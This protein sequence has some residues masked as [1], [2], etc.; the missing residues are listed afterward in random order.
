MKIQIL[1]LFICCTGIYATDVYSQDTKVTIITKNATLKE[2]LHEIEEK[3]DYLFL[4]NQEEVD[5]NRKISLKAKGKRVSH[6]L[7][8]LFDNTDVR[9]V[10]EGNNIVLMKQNAVP[11]ALQAAVAQQDSRI[12]TGAVA[13]KNGEP[14]I[15]ANIMEKGSTNGTITDVDGKFSLN[16]KANAVLQVS[17]I[18][19]ATQEIKVGEQKT[20]YVK[21]NEDAQL[22]EEVVVTA[23]G[24]KRSEK[25]LGY[26]VQKIGGDQFETV[27]GTNIAT[28]LTGRIS[29]LTVFNPT[30]F[31]QDPTVK[32]RGETAI[33]VLDGVPTDLAMRDLNQDDIENINI[34]KGATA[35]ALYG[36]RGG[37]GAIMITTKKSGKK[38]FSVT[39]N[40]SDMFNMGELAL[41]E[42]QTSYSSGIGGKYSIYTPETGINTNFDGVWG[43]KLDIGREAYQWNPYAKEWQM[44]PLTSRGKN[45]FTNFLEASIISNT[46][47][48]VT[49]Q[50]ENGSIR[51]S[52]SYLYNKGQ[53]PNA[54]ANQFR[55]TLGGEMKLGDK[56]SIEGTLG[57][58]KF[59]SPNVSGWG[60]SDQGYIYTLSVWT[61]AEYDVRDYRDYWT[62]PNEQQNWWHHNWYDNPYMSAYEKLLTLDRNKGNGMVS[63]NYQ[64]L[65][66]LK[67]MAR[68][69][70]DLYFNNTERRAP[71][72]IFGTRPWGGTSNGYYS[73]ADDYGYNM[74][75]D[76][77]L[78]YDKKFGRFS[79]DGMLGGSLYSYKKH[80]LN[81]YT[82]GGLTIPG[83]YSLLASVN[84][85]TTSAEL[86]RKA[87]SSV[88]GQ[89][90]LGYANAVYVDV[91]GRNDWSSTLPTGD[92]AYFY[93]SVGGSV[94]LSELLPL[95]E[96]LPFWK[97]RG[98]W[99]VTKSD[100]DIYAINQAY[101]VGT[102]AW[103]TLPSA[104]YPTSL[105]GNVEP[106][107]NR[108]YEIGTA[109]WLLPN[110]R[111]K[112]DVAYFNKL[113]YNDTRAVTI[114]GFTGFASMLVNT[115]EEFVRR[116]WEITLD[117]MPVK[118]NDFSWNSMIN[119]SASHRYFSQLDE[120]YSAD[121]LYT[122]VGERTDFYLPDREFYRTT[123]G[124]LIM[125][126]NG[127]PTRSAYNYFAGYTEPDWI[128]G[129]TNVFKYKNLSL[130]LSFD[131]RT[132]GVSSSITNTRLW[133]TG[134][135]PDSDIPERYEEVVNGN[136]TFVA[137]GVKLVSGAV[138]YDSY[139][140]I[141]P[142]SDT[143]VYAPN[144]IPVSYEAYV[145]ATGRYL[146]SNYM[147]ETFFKLREL[148]LGYDLPKAVVHKA[149]LSGVTISLI[150][151]N[152]LLWTKEYR[153]ADPD[154][155]HSDPADGHA[156]D[157]ASPSVR[158]M[159]INLKVEF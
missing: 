79:V 123:D 73:D 30:E 129:W 126:A 105:R 40:T 2:V 157:L 45:N 24:M 18:G 53:Y 14:I 62:K 8:E 113:T 119:W 93:P 54:K 158:Y 3:T 67:V 134:A 46:S 132:G 84:T 32:L 76:F 81:S 112:L 77:I 94:I 83:Y 57:F 11:T 71:K 90:T 9:Y 86:K 37:N 59:T 4:Y 122:K 142:G 49:Q 149:N 1:L 110:N 128:W 23:L 96:W 95:P 120:E 135:H 42:Q 68:V 80:T 33:I 152:L 27:K 141:V 144:D 63:V 19:Y 98:S 70:A 140:Q 16:V 6:V 88:F 48:S 43:D 151:Q 91:T 12:V 111:L 102:N 107:T 44:T 29:G 99:T 117:A 28:S 36:S 58:T 124:Q 148:S 155:S 72:S 61:G 26:A 74:T 47:V 50:G 56:V 55:Y 65:P 115:K 114:S 133:Q 52:L 137:P 64:I 106:I 85:L 20:I 145:K 7:S 13:D 25:A 15:G 139:G 35:S 22:M 127:Q 41:P 69:G 10:M 51:S 38:G 146:A 143:R 75:G 153:F 100:L 66:G 101:S 97:L 130:S 109:F 17:F 92:N 159:G 78:S 125:G 156:E 150:G 104:A 89:V 34:L 136:I 108:T 147:A 138:E 121:N 39:V 87:V 21:L 82:N 154:N 131:G 118:T 31:S 103:G 116:G 60:Y 5:L